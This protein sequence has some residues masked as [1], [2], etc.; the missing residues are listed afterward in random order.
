L[1]GDAI[2]VQELSLGGAP[3]GAGA[4]LKVGI[5]DSIDIAGYATQLGSAVY[6][7]APQA[8]QHAVV[9]Q[10]L[11]DAG[12]DIVGKTTM[13]ELAYGITGI[14]GWSGTPV[15]PRY[16]DRVPGGSSSGSAV[17]VAASL[18]DFA[19]G[20]DTGGSIRIPAASCGIV[21]LKTTYGRVSRDG[22]H[23][24]TSSLDCVGPFAREL[25][26]I[27]RAMSL[28]DP[29]FIVQKPPAT[30]RLG[31][32]NV[33]AEPVIHEAVRQA[34]D[35]AGIVPQPVT[36]PS[37]DAVFAAG[38][39]II[40]AEN[41]ATYGPIAE[42][43]K[44]GADVRTRLLGAR[45]ITPQALRAAEVCR[46]QFRA[47]VD[48]LF[49]HVDALVL[50]TLPDVPLALAAAGDAAAAIRTTRFVRPFNVSGHPALTLPLQTRAGL[51]A[52][53]QLVGPRGADA[54]LCSLAHGIVG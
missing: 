39:T 47:E 30:I 8:T 34:L 28:I 44:L 25:S 7:D 22:V 10:S 4:G 18:V 15:N 35:R 27:E 23:P 50:P 9:V 52:G 11:L 14:N 20:T 6:L 21:G 46:L 40:G 42:S 26:M 19:L 41:W 32:V 54:A 51:P 2:F 29:T 48:A 16:P 17:A 31:M 38:L 53:L 36:L 45:A 12:C 49:Q 3:R 1:S 37:F 5:K 33:A 13:H 24:R 43:A